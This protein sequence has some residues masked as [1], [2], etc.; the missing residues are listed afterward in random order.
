MSL[1][2]LQT[3]RRTCEMRS[4]EFCHLLHLKM[5]NELLFSLENFHINNSTNDWQ[6]DKVNYIHVLDAH[7]YKEYLHNHVCA[8]N[9]VRKVTFFDRRTGGHLKLLEFF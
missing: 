3:D 5:P 7:R 6:T 9:T 1:L 4:E 2:A 8:F